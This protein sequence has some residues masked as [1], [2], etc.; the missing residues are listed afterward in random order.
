LGN[1]L[2]PLMIGARDLW[3]FHDLN[4]LELVHLH[5]RRMR[6]RLYAII[7]GGVD[8]GWTFYT[9]FSSTF[10]AHFAR[11]WRR[12]W[13]SLSPDF[14]SILT[15]LELCGHHSQNAGARAHLAPPAAVYL[16]DL[17]NQRH[18]HSGHACDLAITLDVAGA[19]ARPAH[20]YL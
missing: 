13:A 19:G 6:S 11:F 18:L 5:R 9:P 2:V 3:P 4:L 14:S 7:S 1:F 8:T 12:R 17:R 20:R 10:S 15:G 16:G